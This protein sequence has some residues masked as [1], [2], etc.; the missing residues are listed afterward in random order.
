[1]SSVKRRRVLVSGKDT[2]PLE[3][4]VPLL[5]TNEVSRGENMGRAWE[6]DV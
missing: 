6:A 5:G 2:I 4:D 3:L 1:M